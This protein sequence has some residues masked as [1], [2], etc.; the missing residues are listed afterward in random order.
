MISKYF[1]LNYDKKDCEKDICTKV[2][3]FNDCITS[4]CGEGVKCTENQFNQVYFRC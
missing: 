1:T 3:L 4:E 2:D